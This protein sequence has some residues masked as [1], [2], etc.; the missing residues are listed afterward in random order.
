MIIS[1]CGLSR[2]Q[3]LAAPW[4]LA[5]QA[6]VSIGFFW[7]EYWSRLPFPS[8]G[9]SSQLRH[10]THISSTSFMDRQILYH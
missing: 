6:P 3:L 1:V 10:Q 2:V 5:H 7:Q 4:T 9:L 8:P